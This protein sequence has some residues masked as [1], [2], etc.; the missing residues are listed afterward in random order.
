MR[1]IFKKVAIL[2]PGLLGGSIALALR[3]KSPRTRIA[4]WARREAAA[5][6]V[7]KRTRADVATT[8]LELAVEDAELVI[9]CVPIGAMP[10]LARKIVKFIPR[11][12]VVTDVGSAK[13]PV[14]KALARIFQQRGKFAGSHPMAGSEQA[15]FGAARADLFDRAVCIVTPHANANQTTIRKIAAFWRL[16]GCEVRTL[17][18]GEHDRVIAF[19]SHLPHFLA[20]ALIDLVCAEDPG[21]LRFSGNGLRDATRVASGPPEMWAEIFDTNREGFRVA[22]HAMIEK[23]RQADKLLQR[24]AEMRRFLAR[25]KQQRDQLKPRK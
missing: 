25:A 16:L 24:P 4:V 13:A 7:R 6:E 8:D 2:G 14:V 22:L 10:P 23:L 9:F 11:G 17:P 20:A 1:M 5:S 21:W 3:E 18:P 12:A 15:G 19:V